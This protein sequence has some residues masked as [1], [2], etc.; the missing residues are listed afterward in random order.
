MTRPAAR[1]ARPGT[2]RPDDVDAHSSARYTSPFG[3]AITSES[4]IKLEPG[5]HETGVGD[6]RNFALLSLSVKAGF[7]DQ[8][9]VA[10]EATRTGP[11]YVHVPAIRFNV[12]LE[13]I[14]R[15]AEP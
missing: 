2:S 10:L 1:R 12:I 6:Q 15:R 11:F 3:V 8:R 9:H 7:G 4:N 5:H 13:T 14:D